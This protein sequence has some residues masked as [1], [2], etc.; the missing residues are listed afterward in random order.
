MGSERRQEANRSHFAFN[1][2]ELLS[3]LK[4]SGYH[5]H[6]ALLKR[7]IQL[8]LFPPSIL[9]VSCPELGS[10][11]GD[12]VLAADRRPKHLLNLLTSKHLNS[13]LTYVPSRHFPP[14]GHRLS[15]G[16]TLGRDA[17]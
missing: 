13:D 15:N 14:H 9:V 8:L 5:K 6:E 4:S 3:H 11:R 16:G 17:R 1:S 12:E 10:S 7:I 2:L